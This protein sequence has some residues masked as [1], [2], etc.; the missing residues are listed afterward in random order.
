MLN[1]NFSRLATLFA[2]RSFSTFSVQVSTALKPDHISRLARGEIG[3]ILVKKYYDS[4]LCL[5]LSERIRNQEVGEYAN[6]SGVLKVSEMGKAFFETTASSDLR[7]E[8]FNNAQKFMKL[9]RDI[10]SPYLSPMDKLRLECDEMWPGGAN[11]LNLNGNKMFSGLT[12]IVESEI[13]PHED[14]LERDL[15]HDIPSELEYVTQLAA[16]VY[17][18]MPSNGGDLCI[19]K[20][21]LDSKQYDLLRGDNY[22]LPEDRIGQHNCSVKPHVGDLVIFCGRNIHAVK[23]VSKGL[24]IGVST[25]IMYSGEGRPLRF[26]S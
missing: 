15:G 3:A 16:N 11:L 10:F 2:S 21:S 26:W 5:A 6:A 24:R 20:K 7:S 23:K 22:F 8:Y 4:D 19:W 13:R 9:N 17:L 18:E 1:L 12:R 25:F 14:K